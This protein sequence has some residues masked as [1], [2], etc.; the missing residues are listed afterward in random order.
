MTFTIEQKTLIAKARIE[1][2]IRTYGDKISIACSF[3]KD[4]IVVLDMA[5]QINPNIL[6]VWSD[7]KV[8]HPL[9]YEYQKRITE[10]WK[11]NLIVAKAP[12]GVN[13]WSLARQYGLPEP[14][15][16]GKNRDP[17]CCSILKQKP[18]EEVYK[19]L[20]IKCVM[21]GITADESRNRYMVMQRNAHRYQNEGVPSD[22]VEGKG[23]GAK[24][25]NKTTGRWALHPI[26][27]WTEQDVWEYIKTNNVEYNPFYDAYPNHRVGCVSCTAYTDWKK[28]MPIESPKTYRKV[29]NFTGQKQIFDYGLKL[30]DCKSTKQELVE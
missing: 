7:T 11:L 24:Y 15:L 3:G 4:S 29:C 18:A 20:G 14:R 19:A 27:D 2:A 1:H 23:C 28:N 16:K 22:D 25:Y 30:S 9:T 12:Q 5:R 21:T 8:E 13:F 17:K 6:V 10:K 26:I